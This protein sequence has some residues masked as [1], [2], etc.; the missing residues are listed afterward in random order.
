VLE[1]LDV[2]ELAVQLQEHVLR[3]VL[4]RIAMRIRS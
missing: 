2:I 4:G 3:E 1:R